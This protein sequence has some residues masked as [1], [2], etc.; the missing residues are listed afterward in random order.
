MIEVHGV[1]QDALDI[2]EP[3]IRKNGIA[4]NCELCRA[5]LHAIGGQLRLQ[6]VIVNLLSNAID[7]SRDSEKPTCS[8]T[9]RC[10][11]EHVYIEVA[12]NGA[13]IDVDVIDQVFEPFFTTKRPGSG[14]GLGLS[15]SFNLIEDFGGNLSAHHQRGAG[16]LFRVRLTRDATVH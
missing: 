3:E 8:L 9:T 12:D 15:I 1:I 14:L 6:Q 10:D 13:G 11:D 4:L 16:A 7:A 2:M 5:P